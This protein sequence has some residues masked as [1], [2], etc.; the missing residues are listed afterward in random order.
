MAALRV[1]V[2][3]TGKPHNP[4]AKGYGMAYQHGQAYK[5]L[6][7]RV[8]LVAC[9]DIV[10][11]N[12]R[13]FADHFGVSEV[14][15]DHKAMLAQ[16][17]LDV[18]SVCVWP[19]LHA[20]LVIDAAGSGVRAIHC[21]KPMADTW[22]NCLK[23]TEA[24][25]KGGVKLTFNHQ[26][27]FGRPFRAAKELLD[28]GAIGD[29]VRVEFTAGNIYDYGTHSIDLCNYFNNEVPAKWVIAQID[30]RDES[31]VFGAHNENQA[32]VQW[33]YQNGVWGFAATGAGGEM[34]GCHNRLVGTDG[35]IEIGRQGQG[36]PVLR[37]RRKG[38][39][40]W[41][42]IDCGK[43][44]VHGPGFIERG[45]AELI[46]ALLT[47]R[48]SE[49]CARNALKAAEITFGAWE[50]A[51]VRGRID[52]PLTITD[53]PLAAMVRSGDLKPQPRSA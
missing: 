47:G 49:M 51:R 23:M 31:L 38:R 8:E 53:N 45:V 27:R 37:V 7:E 44:S 4:S 24:C 50:S 34:V 1:G 30:Y 2:I 26:R 46:E 11:E 36:I 41:E 20:P 43:E 12:A 22:E 6:G 5:A 17:K 13:A 14:Y 32:L 10:A 42:A 15:N 35:V 19:H 52:L 18:V 40:D 28:A 39:A 3:G 29:L 48:D 21:E 9:A 33:Q 16:A 25:E